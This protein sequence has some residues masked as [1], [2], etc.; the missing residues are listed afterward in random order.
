MDKNYFCNKNVLLHFLYFW[1]KR[2]RKQKVT[3]CIHNCI[4][5][6]PKIKMN[7]VGHSTGKLKWMWAGDVCCMPRRYEQQLT[8]IRNSCKRWRGRLRKRYDQPIDQIGFYL[9]NEK[10]V[11]FAQQWRN[12]ET[13]YDGY[14]NYHYSS[15]PSTSV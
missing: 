6:R 15:H 13:Y 9:I 5:L 10:K 1:L 2:R 7:D 8:V 3:S 12:M 4:L 11:T 14:N